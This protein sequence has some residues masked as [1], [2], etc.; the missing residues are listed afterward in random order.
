MEGKFFFLRFFLF[1]LS[2]HPGSLLSTLLPLL[3]VAAKKI[4]LV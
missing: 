4:K 2:A 1:C 3:F